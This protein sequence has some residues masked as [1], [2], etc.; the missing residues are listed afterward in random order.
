MVE[1]VLSESR[2]DGELAPGGCSTQVFGPCKLTYPPYVYAVDWMF[3]RPQG[4]L[5]AF[6]MSLTK[7]RA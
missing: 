7:V 4:W 2:F 5:A 1:W 3:S 6:S